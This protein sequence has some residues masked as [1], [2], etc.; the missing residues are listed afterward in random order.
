MITAQRLPGERVYWGGGRGGCRDFLGG[1]ADSYR[2][3]HLVVPRASMQALAVVTP[4]PTDGSILKFGRRLTPW[5]LINSSTLP[6]R[7]TFHK[8]NNHMMDR[9]VTTYVLRDDVTSC[10]IICAAE[11][12]YSCSPLVNLS[13]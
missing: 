4:D 3:R 13:I 7:A 2:T 6:P 9:Y 10:A 8:P 11:N 5:D 1:G 12:R